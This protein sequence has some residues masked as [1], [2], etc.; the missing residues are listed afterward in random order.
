[1]NKIDQTGIK[2]EPPSH[3][4]SSYRQPLFAVFIEHILFAS[5]WAQAPMYLG[6]AV[7]QV[8]YAIKFL[9]ELEVLVFGFWELT[10]DKIILMVI[11][12]VDV[13]MISNLLVIVI[14]GGY[15]IFVSRM[16][17]MEVHPDRP[18]WLD[19]IDPNTLKIKLITSMISISGVHLL[20]SFIDI[21]HKTDREVIMGI[22]IHL[23]FIVSL[24][25]MAYVDKMSVDK[26]KLLHEGGMG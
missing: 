24:V 10:E 22:C 19:H 4:P 18:N 2:G 13:V 15:S 11:G 14:I 20:K 6:L 12:M 25:A 7:A 17:K 23:T 1:M 9:K 21:A 3:P 16:I 8:I 5:R 26:Q